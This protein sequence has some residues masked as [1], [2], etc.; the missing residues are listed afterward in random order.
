[1]TI[2]E[3]YKDIFQIKEMAGNMSEL[4]G[5]EEEEE[6]RDRAVVCLVLS[7][8]ILAFLG[9]EDTITL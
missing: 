8:M 6:Q 2:T 9:K 5:G 4:T 3:T 7:E 1:M